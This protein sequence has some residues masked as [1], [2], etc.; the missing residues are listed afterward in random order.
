MKEADPFQDETGGSDGIL[1]VPRILKTMSADMVRLVVL[2]ARLFGHTALA[3]I[4]LSLLVA[5]LLV[6]S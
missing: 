5:L 3:M 1:D 2:E 6:S 4:G